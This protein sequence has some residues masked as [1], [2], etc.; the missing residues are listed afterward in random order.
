M[1]SKPIYIIDLLNQIDVALA[2]IQS[3]VY[4][5]SAL[6]S[7]SLYVYG[8][9]GLTRLHIFHKQFSSDKPILINC[10]LQAS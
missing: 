6:M 3:K 8:L 2:Y 7:S 5:N 4:E 10:N 1:R 9:Y